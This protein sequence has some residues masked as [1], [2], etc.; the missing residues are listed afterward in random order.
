MR[1]NSIT[2][3]YF[4]MFSCNW[5]T[6]KIPIISIQVDIFMLHK[7]Y[8][9]NFIMTS[10][11]LGILLAFVVILISST[12]LTRRYARSVENV[13]AVGV[14]SREIFFLFR[15]RPWRLLSHLK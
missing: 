13:P 11:K 5:L 7:F 1:N 2:L 8:V 9:L 12:S 10:G 3:S 4:I 14:R 15:N 6:K